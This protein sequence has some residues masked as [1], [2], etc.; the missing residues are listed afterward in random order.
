M[1]LEGSHDYA[2]PL[3]D[4]LAMLRDEAATIAK[5]ESMGHRD[6]EIVECTGDDT[7]LRIVSSRVV[8]VDLPG[9][10]KKVLKPTNTM[11]QTDDWHEAGGRWDGTFDV[12]VQGAPVHISGAMHLTTDGTTTTHAV[13]IDV[14]VKV[15]LVGGKIAD[16][17]GKNDVRKTLDAEF[18]FGDR[19]LSGER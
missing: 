17:V 6:V 13:T 19:W 16:W 8:D 1:K 2:A 4:V 10:A 15:P 11:R 18:A 5:Y 7:T 9:F 12:A 3:A 14:A